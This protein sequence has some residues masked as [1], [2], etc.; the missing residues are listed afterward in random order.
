MTTE[1]IYN[2][3]TD[4]ISS[5]IADEWLIARVDVRMLTDGQDI[6]FEGTY[7]TPAGEAEQLPTDWP[8]EVAEAV[9]ALYLIR[10]NEGH[11]HANRLQIDLTAQGQFTT[12]FSWDQELQDED[13][14]FANG[15]T[16]RE[17]VAIRE[18]KYG[19]SL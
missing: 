10:V 5:T 13:D 4:A 2:V 1:D 17:W 11:P 12:E 6:E 14:H 8:V 3:L 18:A 16:V 9:Q 15:G 19:S 7:L